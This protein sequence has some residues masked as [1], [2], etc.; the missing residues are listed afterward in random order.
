M[1]PFKHVSYG[2]HIPVLVRALEA[3]LGPKPG[4]IVELGTGI[5]S[6]PLLHWLCR[7]QG[8]ELV[9]LENRSEFL[10]VFGIRGYSAPWHYVALIEDWGRALLEQ[11]WDVALVDH[12]PAERRATD[13]LRLLPWTKIVVVHD[14][15]WWD[16]KH[17]GFRRDLFPLVRYVLHYRP[18][19]ER[20][21][22]SVLS[23][24]VDVSRL[25]EVGQWT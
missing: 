24:T 23:Q 18:G 5:Y 14:T 2:S 6:T 11:P 10:D 13:A 3:T 17:Y 8:R 16:D 7:W 1:R 4:R 22:T 9:S 20:V 19:P 25:M 15:G 12:E 21:Q